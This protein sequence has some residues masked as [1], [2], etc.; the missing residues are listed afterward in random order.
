[1]ISHLLPQL[2]LDN[3]HDTHA[4]AVKRVQNQEG[5]QEMPLTLSPV[6]HLFLQ[7]GGQIWVEVAGKRRN[8]GIVMEIPAILPF[9]TRSL[10]K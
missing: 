2:E 3:L 5:Q 8:K 1:M 6:F 9:I 10:Q 4:A 7:H